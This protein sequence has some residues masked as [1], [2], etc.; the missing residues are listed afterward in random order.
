M[1]Q[2]LLAVLLSAAISLSG[3]QPMTV[4][5][6][7]AILRVS[8]EEMKREVCPRDPASCQGIAAIFDADR[9]RIL[10]DETLNMDM[11]DDNSFVVHELVHVLQYRQRGSWM[12]ANC[13]ES[14]DTEAQAYQVQNAYLRRAGRLVRFYQRLAF[15]GCDQ[16]GRVF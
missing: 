4:D 13:T 9:Q 5:E 11:A 15:A 16:T 8:H 3:L 10:I 12:Y 14:M 1:D 2:E 6:L 7:P